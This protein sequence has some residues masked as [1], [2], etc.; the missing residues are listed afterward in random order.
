MIEPLKDSI[1][2]GDV[3][4]IYNSIKI[5][6]F[7][8]PHDVYQSL[9]AHHLTAPNAESTKSPNVMHKFPAIKHPATVT[10]SDQAA[11]PKSNT[12]F[13]N[14]SPNQNYSIK[15]KPSQLDDALD[16][17][18]SSSQQNQNETNQKSKNYDPNA[19]HLVWSDMDGN[20]ASLFNRD[21]SLIV[22]S[23]SG[24]NFGRK[25]NNYDNFEYLKRMQQ[26]CSRL[27]E[28]DSSS[29]FKIPIVA[30][31]NQPNYDNSNV[32][33]VMS[34][35][36]QADNQFRSLPHEQV[37]DPVIASHHAN[38]HSSNKTISLSNHQIYLPPPPPPPTSK[39]YS[40][41]QQ[42]GDESY[43]RIARSIQIWLNVNWLIVYILIGIFIT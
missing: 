10:F 5:D 40:S 34:H 25:K 18:Q 41:H 3:L 39:I 43:V 1:I 9:P 16:A 4:K 28:M 37:N 27:N 31:S 30:T 17:A 15:L 23:A 38:K 29:I 11:Q 42:Q 14:L 21:N 36:D 13:Y 35:F 2:N 26:K 7:E 22:K 8:L 12:F 6:N 24:T 19:L 32:V 20:A 33:R